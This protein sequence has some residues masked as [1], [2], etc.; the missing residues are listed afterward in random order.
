MGGSNARDK[1]LL[2]SL[3]GKSWWS[4]GLVG[5]GIFDPDLLIFLTNGDENAVVHFFA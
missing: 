4:W 3:F 2:L 1:N 5:F